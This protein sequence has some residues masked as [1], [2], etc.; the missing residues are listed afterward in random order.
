MWNLDPRRGARG[1]A[2]GALALVGAA[3]VSL[4]F[5]FDAVPFMDLPAH[6]GLFA[7]RGR[8]ATSPF[9]QP[10]YV[11]APH[12]GGYSMF[13]FL[14]AALTSVFGPLR[15]ARALEAAGVVAL[16]L[17]VLD[18][19]RRLYGRVSPG[20]GFLGITLAFGLMTVFGFASF[21]LGM[22]LLVECAAVVLEL[23]AKVE[24]RAPAWQHEIVLGALATLL[25]L[26]HGFAFAVF[27]AVAGT[28]AVARGG[29]PSRFVRGRALVPAVS[30]G[31]WA[32]WVERASALPPGSAPA[33]QPRAGPLFQSLADKLSLLLSPTLMTRTGV[34]VA[35]GLGVWAVVAAGVV[36]TIGWLRRRAA[37][38]PPATLEAAAH[39]RAL[40]ACAALLSCAFLALPHEIG[41]FGFVDG[42]LV[43]IILLVASLGLP[44]PAMGRRLVTAFERAVPAAACIMVGL[45]FLASH[46]FQREAAGYSQVMARVP[47]LTRVL[48][49]PIDPNSDVFA[50]HPFVHY[51]KL[52]V[53]ERPVIVSDLW[54]HQGSA[55]FPR[56]CNPVLA[57]P[58]DYLPSD[59]R[60]VDWSRFVLR[61]WDFVL[62]RTRPGARAPSAP[63]EL[64][65]VEH[66]GGW[67]LYATSP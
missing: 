7:L 15:A 17:A 14:G 60:E 11:L 6:A 31:L 67:W 12:V 49:L 35:V 40:L 28:A 20:F 38:D 44:D 29:R 34:D 65:L 37:D 32:V 13:R 50:G 3:A 10:F 57:L 33:P 23:L 4:F 47:P 25:L 5:A 43:P 18:G 24:A 41:W 22:A 36:S 59:I 26:T 42:R 62:V 9:E 21:L 1:W 48:N 2:W 56:P 30:L 19:R 16:P 53:A 52:I 61:D 54:L 63:G 51:D 45:A 27:L 55:I 58:A 64:R 46:L 66:L 39:A 8:L